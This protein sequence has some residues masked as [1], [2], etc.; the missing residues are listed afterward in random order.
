[1]SFDAYHKWL[2]IPPHQ[3]PPHHYRLLGV[4]PFETDV[5]VIEAAA[6][7]RLAYLQ[8]LA[9]GDQVAESQKLL[10]EISQARR[11]LLNP[12]KKFLYDMEL[13][14][15]L[16]AAT[17][18]PATAE[19]P[20]ND[21]QRRQFLVIGGILV[22]LVLIV[23]LFF[24]SKGGNGKSGSETATIEIDWPLDQREGAQVIVQGKPMTLPGDPIARLTV[25]VGRYALTLRRKGYRDISVNLVMLPGD[26]QQ[27]RPNWRPAP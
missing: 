14:K 3:Q 6:N 27:F 2:G 5:D 26:L 4:D 13:R 17:P 23:G 10:N 18:K 7:Q 22:A 19:K 25:P 15:Q 20:K 9:T 12:E 8:D 24:M 21:L 1:M 16:D 11:T